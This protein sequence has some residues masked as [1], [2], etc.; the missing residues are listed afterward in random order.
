M[1]AS[2]FRFSVY[3]F[4]SVLTS[5]ELAGWLCNEMLLQISEAGI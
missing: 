3:A 5:G 1:E 2:K 4:V